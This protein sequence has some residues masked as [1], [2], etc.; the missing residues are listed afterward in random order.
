M[1]IYIYIRVL[2]LIVK[3]AISKYSKIS[4]ENSVLLDRIFADVMFTFAPR[5]SQRIENK[6][7]NFTEPLTEY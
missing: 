7:H 1:E 5:I 6:P 4:K 2:N 3:Y